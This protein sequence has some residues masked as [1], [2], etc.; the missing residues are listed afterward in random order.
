MGAALHPLTI[1]SDLRGELYSN[2]KAL[3]VALMDM[4]TPSMV[5]VTAQVLP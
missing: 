4:I 5:R 1:Y 3:F 2:F